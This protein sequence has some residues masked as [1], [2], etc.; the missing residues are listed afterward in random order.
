MK[1]LI[2]I[3]DISLADRVKLAH[4]DTYNYQEL[5][6]DPNDPKKLIDNP[7]TVEDLI[8]KKLLEYLEEVTSRYELKT[9]KQNLA[10]N[11]QRIDLK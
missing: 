5:I 10:K 3:P 8:K 4:A 6:D 1:I 7:E 11:F 2:D 9:Q